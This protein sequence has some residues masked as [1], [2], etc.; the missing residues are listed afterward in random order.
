MR[1]IYLLLLTTMSFTGLIFGVQ[2]TGANQP[3]PTAPLS[4]T[5]QRTQAPTLLLTR[6][7]V[8]ADETIEPLTQTDLQVITGNVQRPNGM[9]GLEGKLTL[10]CLY[11]E[12]DHKI[13]KMY[14]S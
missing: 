1:K 8:E 12:G 9:V 7:A 10:C 11:R 14:G 2:F 5:Q 3:T 6:E 4:K 13:D